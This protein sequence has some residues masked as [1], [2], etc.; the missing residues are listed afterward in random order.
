MEEHLMRYFYPLSVLY[1]IFVALYNIY[2]HSLSV[3]PGPKTAAATKIPIAYVSWT[4]KLSHWQLALHERYDSDVVRISPDE[5]SF[6]S[7]SAWKDMYGTRQGGTN[8]FSKDLVLYTGIDS[9]V[10][11]NDADH[12]RMRRLLSHAFSDKAL[13]EQETIIQSHVNNLIAGLRKRCTDYG[14]KAD[15]AKWFNWTTF[16]ILGDL[17]F[18]EPFDCLKE[19]I[20]RP[21]VAM[22]MNNHRFIVLMSVTLRFPP[23]NRLAA[24]FVPKKV[25]QDNLDHRSMS[26][27]KVDRRVETTTDRPDF[28]SYILRHSGTKR[29]MSREELHLHAAT[30]IAA[31][32]ET[33]AT[34]LAGAVWSLLRHPAYMDR[35]QQEIRSKFATADEIR[36]AHLDDLEFLHAVIS[37]SFRMYPPAVAGQPRVAPPTGDFISGYWVPP[38]TGVQI[39]QYAASMS[40]RNFSSPWTF[41]PSRW[42]KDPQYADDK[43]DALQPFSVGARSCIG[44]NLA[45]AESAL[46]LTRL[47]WEFDITLSKETS[48]N[49]PDQ[50]AWFTWKMNP[51]V[52]NLKERRMG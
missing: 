46:I 31:G 24:R 9:I 40:A 37:E 43:L 41:A 14:G 35:L 28:M 6:I 1:M 29:G 36:F 2:F 3:Y 33:T 34:L 15:L 12:S 45:N 51:L 19:T 44:K 17:A 39:N 4:G 50:Q 5:L 18:G 25:V 47:L 30:F 10:T 21:W 42:M 52:V 16:D 32:S 7:P 8:P 26:K 49:W 38:K 48:S 13:R 11:A 22:L 23:L 20:Y 27:E